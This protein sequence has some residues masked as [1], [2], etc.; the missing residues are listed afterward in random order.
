MRF[1]EVSLPGMY[2]VI[3]CG[4]SGTRLWPLSRKG[5]PK[6]FLKLYSDRSL[7]Q[8]TYARVRRLMPPEH[9]FCITN[10]E[11]RALALS[12][13][14]EMDERFSETNII[15]EPI[16]LNTAPAVACAV[17]YLLSQMHVSPNE[18][19]LFLPADH[20][21]ENVEEFVTVLKRAF[22]H[23]GEN[24][25]TIGIH[26]SRPETGYGYIQKGEQE[27]GYFQ[28]VRFCEKPKKA[29]AEQYVSSGEYVWNSGMYL[30][31]LAAFLRETEAH[32]PEIYALFA[33]EWEAFLER[34][35]ALPKIS[36]DYAISEKSRQMVVFEGNF[37]WSDIGSYDSLSEIS[38]ASQT[39]HVDIDSQGVFVQSENNRLIATI[40]LEDIIIIES[41][42]GILVCKRGRSEEVK[43]IV[44]QVKDL[45]KRLE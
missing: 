2:A 7:L 8:E 43:Q 17:K 29:I 14:R 38:K 6:H 10:E 26:A 45:N 39:R 16:S 9:I 24:I 23:V 30:F 36:I 13:I 11:G 18:K 35:P 34:F 42:E 27:N 4:G 28:A 12:H 40:G 31:S 21:I 33:L 25:G 3:L 37:G 20:Y 32:A 15:V 1:V 19:V 44:D 22:E 41:E 5:L